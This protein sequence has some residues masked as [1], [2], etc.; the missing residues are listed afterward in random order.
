MPP[1]K[2]EKT[3]VSD[4]HY[5]LPNGDIINKAFHFIMDP[6]HFEIEL[7]DIEKEI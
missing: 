4:H 5:I 6:K 3:D 2:I 1:K 7:V